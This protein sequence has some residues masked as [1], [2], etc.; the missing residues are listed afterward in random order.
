[1]GARPPLRPCNSTHARSNGLNRVG[2]SR[3]DGTPTS[4]RHTVRTASCLAAMMKDAAA[5]SAA[6]SRGTR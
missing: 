1:M 2:K 4:R 3:K 5:G 6:P